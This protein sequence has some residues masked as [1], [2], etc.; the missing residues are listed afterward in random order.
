MSDPVR[1]E[2]KNRDRLIVERNNCSAGFWGI[3][4]RLAW[5]WRS[6]SLTIRL[7]SAM[8]EFGRKT[9]TKYYNRRTPLDRTKFHSKTKRSL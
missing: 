5:P 8:S 3:L 9:R 7:P 1:N 2:K 6:R 4:W